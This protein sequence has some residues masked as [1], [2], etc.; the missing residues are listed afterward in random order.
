MARR[1]IRDIV[2]TAGEDATVREQSRDGVAHVSTTKRFFTMKYPFPPA[3][4]VEFYRAY[5]GP[6]NRAFVALDAAGSRTLRHDL[7][8]LWSSN[9]LAKDGSTHVEA[10]LLHVTANRV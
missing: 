2:F 3:E 5:Y 9:N 1:S 4:V 6:T 7:E 8:V 10:E